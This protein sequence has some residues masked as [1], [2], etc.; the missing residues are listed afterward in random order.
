MDEEEKINVINLRSFKTTLMLIDPRNFR[1][2]IRINNSYLDI[3]C[4]KTNYYISYINI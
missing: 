3:F 2:L 4:K 1:P